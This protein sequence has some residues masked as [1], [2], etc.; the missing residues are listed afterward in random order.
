MER[1]L[2]IDGNSIL[3]RAYFALPPLNTK[4]GVNVN[5]VYGFINM[6][7]KAID[8]YKPTHVAVAFDKKGE[9]FRKKLFEGYKANRKGMPDDLAAQMPVI[10]DVLSSMD[11]KILEKAGVEADDIIGTVSRMLDMQSYIIISGD[12]DMLQLVDAT[13][14]V[15]LTKRG[16]TDVEINDE[17]SIME[18]YGLTPRQIIEYKALCGDASDN[19]PGVPGIGDKGAK[20]LLAAYGDIDGIYANVDAMKGATQKKLVEGKESAYLSRQLATIVLDADIECQKEE[21]ELIYPFPAKARKQLEE[22][23]FSAVIKRLAFDDGGEDEAAQRKLVAEEIVV[24]NDEELDRVIEEN[25]EQKQAAVDFSGGITFAFSAERQYRLAIGETL[26]D[27]VSAN[28]A[29][30]ALSGIFG[31]KRV[32][33]YD[34]KRVRKEC[35][36]LGVEVKEISDLSLMEYIVA[37]RQSQSKESFFERYGAEKHCAAMFE[38]EKELRGK[39][40]ETDTEKLYEEIEL[41]LSKILYEMEKEGCKV[42]EGVI[43]E[44]SAKYTSEINELSEKVWEMAGE[45][46]NILSPKQLSV[47]LFEKL[48]LSTFGNKKKKTGYST[49]AETMEKLMG[50][51]PIIP[52][53]MRIRQL[54]KLCGTYIEGMR[55]YIKGGLIHTSFNQTQTITGRLSSSEPNLQNLPIRTDEGREIRR[56]FLPKRDLLISADYSQ[57]EL[58]LLAHFSGDKALCKA[59]NE[60][61]DIHAHVAS[62]LFDI[63]EAFVSSNM[64]RTAKA[65]NFGIIYG[66]SDYGL[67][68]NIKLSPMKAREYIRKYFE[69]YPSIKAYLDGCIEKA[70]NDGFVTTITNRRR[71]LPEINSKNFQLRSFAERAAMNMPLQG[72]AADIIKIAMINVDRALKKSGLE[73]RMILQIHDELVIDAAENEAEEV[74][75]ILKR[76]MENAVETKVKL[77]VNVESGRTMYEAK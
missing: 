50:E 41:P 26:F 66:I 60:E 8:E 61:R 59:F 46:F 12:R 76:E 38:I 22:L 6:L 21:C 30:R 27:G 34:S 31:E 40:V 35:D 53:I 63:P 19:I 44:L 37:Y 51:H 52:L 23:E 17:N 55:E 48:K 28:A 13:T 39:L 54:S 10:H 14:T 18:N 45:R 4:D 62:E 69:R 70:R 15:A 68:Q 72:S 3:N 29:T 47:I 57:I 33:V 11:I 25:R 67:S 9:N 43:D 36:S 20:N 65:V 49:D 32:V 24:A 5:A 56:L 58:R 77:T 2:L 73:S 75:A 7:I 1:L 16:I 42:D 64:R 71:M 74:K